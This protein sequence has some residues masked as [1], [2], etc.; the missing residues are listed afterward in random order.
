MIGEDYVGRI[1]YTEDGFTRGKIVSIVRT[2]TG[3][4]SRVNVELDKP[5]AAGETH[6]QWFWVDCKLA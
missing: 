3:D 2:R 4:V 6:V 5:N 1:V